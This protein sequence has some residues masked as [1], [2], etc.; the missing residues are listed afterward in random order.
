MIEHEQERLKCWSKELEIRIVDKLLKVFEALHGCESGD[1]VGREAIEDQ[2]GKEESGEVEDF[3]GRILWISVV[4][5]LG[6]HACNG[7]NAV[8]K[9]QNKEVHSS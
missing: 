5:L 7:R 8:G 2:H 3:H 1:N 9:C 6:N 4:T